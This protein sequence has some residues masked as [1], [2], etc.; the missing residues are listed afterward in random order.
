MLTMLEVFQGVPE[1]ESSW[2]G[3]SYGLVPSLFQL[4]FLMQVLMNLHTKV[5]EA[6]GASLKHYE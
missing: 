3:A 1:V 6:D 5:S 4:I 2:R